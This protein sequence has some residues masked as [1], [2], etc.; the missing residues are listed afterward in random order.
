MDKDKIQYNAA[1]IY[2]DKRA[3]QIKHL[4]SKILI[5]TLCMSIYF[6]IYFM[7]KLALC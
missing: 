4:D 1:I 3:L 5:I 6:A 7:F 2:L